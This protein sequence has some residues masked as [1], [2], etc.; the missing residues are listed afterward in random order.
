MVRGENLDY[1]LNT[2]SPAASMLETKFFVNSVVSD[3]KEVYRFM[4]CDL[5]D[6]FHV[7]PWTN[8]TTCK[9]HTSPFLR[10]VEYSIILKRNFQEV[11]SM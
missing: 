10:T 5:N 6:L 4:S 11:S 1:D 7:P 2:G 9:S 8:H 3:A